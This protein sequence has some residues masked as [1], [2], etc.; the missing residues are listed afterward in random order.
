MLTIA[1][2]VALPWMPS[3]SKTLLWGWLAGGLVY[4]YVVVTV[5]RV[6]Y[7]LYPLLPLCALVIGG[8]AARFVTYVR[9]RRRRADRALRAAGTRSDRRRR[10]AS[11]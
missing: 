7:Y 10:G 11:R 9:T 2:F 4:V 1:C 6:D 8:A 3:R 5:E